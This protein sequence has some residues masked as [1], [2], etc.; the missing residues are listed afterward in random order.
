MALRQK[1]VPSFQQMF[2]TRA[3]LTLTNLKAEQQASVLLTKETSLKLF[4]IDHSRPGP[5]IIKKE[6]GIFLFQVEHTHPL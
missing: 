5:D 6:N 1:P 2:L 4:T 3:S